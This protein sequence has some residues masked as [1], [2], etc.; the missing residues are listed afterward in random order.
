MP[1]WE[2]EP[3]V[4]GEM[5][6][7]SV[8]DTAVHPPVVSQF[9]LEVSGWM[10]DCLVECFP[11][12]AVTPALAMA[13]HGSD[14]TGF[15]LDT[16]KTTPGAMWLDLHE[17]EPVPELEWLRVNGTAGAADFGL[18]GSNTIVVS[19]RALRVLQTFTLDQADRTGWLGD[20]A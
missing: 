8:L 16:M 2:L 17:D 12:F 15:S 4:P 1:F 6:S 7:D 10:G 3:E 20:D 18:S 9:H 13:L 5:G 14:L 19:D 11:C